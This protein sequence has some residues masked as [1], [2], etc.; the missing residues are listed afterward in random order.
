MITQ[1][2]VSGITA[3]C[4]AA[5]LVGCGGGGSSSSTSTPTPGAMA[6]PG[7]TMEAQ[8][9][10][11]APLAQAAPVPPGLKCTG[12]VMVWVNLDRKSYHESTDPYFGRTKSGKYM[13]KA[14]AVTAGYHAAGAMHG[15]GHGY[16]SAPAPAAT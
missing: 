3:I 15:H 12:D 9:T 7:A 6:A 16:G 11:G 13:C 14:D 4:A 1:R 5:I 10:H 2:I 8:H